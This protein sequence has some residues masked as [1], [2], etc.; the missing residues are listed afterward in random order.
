MLL[1]N[2]SKKQVWNKIGV[3]V[4]LKSVQVS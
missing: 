2:K 3:T 1:V 4:S